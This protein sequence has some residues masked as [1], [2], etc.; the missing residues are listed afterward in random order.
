MGQEFRDVGS[1]LGWQSRE[2][3]FQV[4]IGI[5]PVELGGL[6]QAHDRSRPLAG[7]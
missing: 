7:A 3:V 6:D 4:C 2:H 5:M 1:L